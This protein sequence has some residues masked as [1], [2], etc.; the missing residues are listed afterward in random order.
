VLLCILSSSAIKLALIPVLFK[1]I[2]SVRLPVAL[3][4]AG[5][6]RAEAGAEVM[7]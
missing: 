4:I 2:A 3:L 6:R 7:L 1:T 5:Q